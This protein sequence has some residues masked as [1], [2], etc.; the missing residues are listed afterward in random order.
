[1]TEYGN[2]HLKKL[3]EGLMTKQTKDEPT[4]NP[5]LD[6]LE[7]LSRKTEVKRMIIFLQEREID[8]LHKQKELAE[9]LKAEGYDID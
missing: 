1:V 9:Q 4:N 6:Y 3:L 2:Q 5:R 8:L 7:I